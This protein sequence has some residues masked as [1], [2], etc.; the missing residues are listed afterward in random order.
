MSSG[1]LQGCEIGL[2]IQAKTKQKC[3][4]EKVDQANFLSTTYKCPKAML[5]RKKFNRGVCQPLV[6]YK[7]KENLLPH[8]KGTKE[9]SC[10]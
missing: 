10:W 6:H 3:V 5:G 4:E 8:H 1:L 2:K 9:E 7:G